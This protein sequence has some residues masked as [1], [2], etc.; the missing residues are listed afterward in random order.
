MNFEQSENQKM[1][2]ES[3]RDFAKKEINSIV[4][5]LAA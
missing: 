1:I 2:A 3:I 5:P 4:K